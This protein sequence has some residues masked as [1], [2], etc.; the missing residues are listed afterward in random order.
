MRRFMLIA[1]AVLVAVAA[2]V[3]VAR[4]RDS[5]ESARTNER[6]SAAETRESG[7]RAEGGA[8]EVQ[9]EQ[10]ETAERL[11][12][13]AEA[14]ADGNF[15]GAVAATTDP[16][17]GWVGSRLLKRGTD[18]WEPATATDPHAPWVYLLTTRYGEPKPCETG[19]CPTP[20]I[21]SF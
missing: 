20:Y 13:L 11:E 4:A 17:P 5:G 8:E 3:L 10:E 2:A 9:E 6:A 16:A 19:H 7:G 21:V 15:G 14:K 1:L 18:D 12:A